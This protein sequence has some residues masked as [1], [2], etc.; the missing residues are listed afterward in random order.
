MAIKIKLKP[1]MLGKLTFAKY[2]TLLRIKIQ[3]IKKTNETVPCLVFTNHI[4]PDP[5]LAKRPLPLILIGEIPTIWNEQFKNHKK[6]GAKKG[7]CTINQEGAFVFVQESAA[8]NEMSIKRMKV[9]LKQVKVDLVIKETIQAKQTEQ[10]LDS[11]SVLP[12]ASKQQVSGK[13]ENQKKEKAIARAKKELMNQGKD[14]TAIVKKY[15]TQFE[16]IQKEV[17]PKLKSGSTNRNDS[18]KVIALRE[19]RKQFIETFDQSHKKVQEK[20]SSV[21]S[22]IEKQ[23]KELRQLSLAV[24]NKKKTMAQ[25]IADFFFN[26]N[27]QRNATEMEVQL[28]QESLKEGFKYRK[29]KQLKGENKQLNIRAVVS[30]LK[31]RGTRFKVEDTDKV[32]EKITSA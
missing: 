3:K 32:Y 13:K 10:K 27:E 30:T 14:L 28:F 23:K 21:R 25:K 18:K 26:K 6:N 17:I 7:V 16:V 4:F 8:M 20:F 31:Y 5:K 2:T 19:L 22:Q 9:V 12:G 24:K 11:A 15:K 1:E 29:I